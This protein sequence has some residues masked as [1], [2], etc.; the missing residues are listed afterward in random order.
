MEA[1]I[2]VTPQLLS[3]IAIMERQAASGI[4]TYDA[5]KQGT[6]KNNFV[7]YTFAYGKFLLRSFDGLE[8]SK[9]GKRIGKNVFVYVNQP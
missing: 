5:I 7:P 3:G 1:D 9:L 4:Q 8:I 6:W 2:V